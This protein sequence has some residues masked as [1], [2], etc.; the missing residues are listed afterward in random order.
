MKIHTLRGTVVP[1]TV[2][3]LIVDDGRINHGYR[4]TK[5]VVAGDP[6]DAT[7]EAFAT[8]GRDYDTP[9][10]W[11]WGD[12][13]QV[14]WAASHIRASN[15]MDT[16]FILVDQEVVVIQ[17][18]YIQGASNSPYIN[19]YIELE[20]ITLT[21]DEAIITLIKERSQDDQR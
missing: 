11:N 1:G 14:G 18:L 6:R 13:R 5:F 2:K 19:Y 8:L 3:R 17:D 21:D 16:P 20:E 12:N 4:I 15:S 7:D 10:V 9:L